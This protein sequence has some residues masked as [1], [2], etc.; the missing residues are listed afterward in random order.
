MKFIFLIAI[1][2]LNIPNAKRNWVSGNLNV[3]VNSVNLMPKAKKLQKEIECFENYVNFLITEHKI[4]SGHN[5]PTL[6]VF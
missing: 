1:L 4:W 5:I 2:C 6:N 3:I